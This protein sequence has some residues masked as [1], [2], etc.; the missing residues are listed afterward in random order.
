MTYHL[1]GSVRSSARNASYGSS[2]SSSSVSASVGSTS[3][4]TV[5]CVSGVDGGLDLVDD[6]GR[7]IHLGDE[8]LVENR[9]VLVAVDVG[10]VVGRHVVGVLGGVLGVL[11][12]ERVGEHLGSSLG[13]VGLV[14]VQSVVHDRVRLRVV[15]VDVVQVVDVVLVFVLVDD[16]DGEV[17]GRRVRRRPLRRGCCPPGLRRP[18]RTAPQRSP[19]RR[20][21]YIFQTLAFSSVSWAPDPRSAP[22]CDS[23]GQAGTPKTTVVTQ[24]NSRSRP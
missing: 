11:L 15:D 4:S 10:A 3:P 21:R 9:L 16:V 20:R 22:R 17:L 7:G 6:G 14:D 1:P 23:G 24:T 2:S 5:G 8:V 13:L 12:G 18:P 19:S